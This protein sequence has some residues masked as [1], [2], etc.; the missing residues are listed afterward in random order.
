ML[1]LP[2]FY[3]C[4][5]VFMR[6]RIAIIIP[7]KNEEKGIRAVMLDVRKLRI[8]AEV[9][10]VDG[11]SSD[12]TVE[13]AKSMGAKIINEKRKG[14]GRAYKTAFEKLPKNVKFVA[15]LDGDGTYPVFRIPGLVN[16]LRKEKIDFI[17]CRRIIDGNMCLKHKIGNKVLTFFTDLLFDVDVKDSQSGMWVFRRKVL[18]GIKPKSDGMAFSEEL[19]ILVASNG[20]A[21]REIPIEYMERIGEVKLKSFEDGF[22]NLLFLFKLKFSG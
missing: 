12:R 18:Y 14:Y 4:K 10:V 6:N 11:N 5:V 9:L 7:T 13:M 2:M 16:A 22:K 20:F 21:F 19:K 15:C 3:H 8:K 17:S 1:C